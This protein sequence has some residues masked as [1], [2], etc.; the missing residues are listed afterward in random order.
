M[1][2]SPIMASVKAF[3]LASTWSSYWMTW[4][5][6]EHRVMSLSVFS[7]KGADRLSVRCGRS[8]SSDSWSWCFLNIAFS[9]E[10]SF[11]CA[12]FEHQR[13]LPWWSDSRLNINSFSVLSNSKGR[14][15]SFAFSLRVFIVH[16]VLMPILALAK[17]PE[18]KDSAFTV[19]IS[20]EVAVSSPI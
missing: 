14:I 6:V 13:I 1:N 3:L 10:D 4:G 17:T 15:T 19:N 16:V 2:R 18:R 8:T 9:E 11:C 7:E 20:K 5:T 12:E